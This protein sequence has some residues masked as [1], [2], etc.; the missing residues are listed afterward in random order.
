MTFIDVMKRASISY[1]TKAQLRGVIRT[2]KPPTLTGFTRHLEEY[3]RVHTAVYKPRD[4]YL[5]DIE[6]DLC[7]LWDPEMP[8][9]QRPSEY[10]NYVHSIPLHLQGAHW[11]ILSCAHASGGPMIA[12]S[13]GISSFFLQKRDITPIKMEF[14][15]WTCDWTEVQKYECV[16]EVPEIFKR[17][18]LVNSMIYED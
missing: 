10:V 7:A 12:E 18:T 14:D 2:Q 11:Y 8:S 13:L 4:F 6:R 15:R 17:A 3:K 1:H 5:E 9:F 16:A